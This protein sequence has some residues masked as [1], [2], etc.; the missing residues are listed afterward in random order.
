MKLLADLSDAFGLGATRAMQVAHVIWAGVFAVMTFLLLAGYIHAV[1]Y[2]EYQTAGQRWLAHQPLY[3]LTN[4]DGFQYF[5]QAALVFAPFA[6]LGWPLGDVL[7]RAIG[8]GLYALG[9]WRLACQLKPAQAAIVYLYATVLAIGPAI[10]NLVNGQANLWLAALSLHIAVDLIEQRYWRAT[11][12]L[13]F[14]FGLKPLLGVLLLLVLVLYRPMTWRLPLALCVVF[15]SPWLLRDHAYVMTQY[16]ECLTKL[17]LCAQPDRQFEDVRGLF[18]SLGWTM[19]QPAYLVLR[20]IAALGVLALCVF[21]RRALRE[22]QSSFYVTAFATSYLML[23]NPRTLS[24]SYVMTG[25]LGALLTARYMLERRTRA[26]WI[27]LAVML[28]WTINYHV[29]PFV[30][31]WLRPLACL[32]FL[33]LLV[34]EMRAQAR[35]QELAGL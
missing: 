3:D 29:L 7:W 31:H 18:S 27:A 12:L 14:G 25:A 28:A 10:G 22:P 19:E 21:A 17:A 26:A 33:A 11:A 20:A 15:V 16:R 35:S 13:A 6:K 4:I 8:W 2:H 30:E 32:V 24:T 1:P 9:I 23:F 5:P 34:Y